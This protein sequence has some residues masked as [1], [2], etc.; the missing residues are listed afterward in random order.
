VRFRPEPRVDGRRRAPVKGGGHHHDQYRP[1]Q[2]STER[3][4]FSQAFWLEVLALHGFGIT[5]QVSLDEDNMTMS[6]QQLN[7]DD[8]VEER[9]KILEDW[10]GQLESI[11]DDVGDLIF[12]IKSAEPLTLPRGIGHALET[13]D[14]CLNRVRCWL[15]DRLHGIPPHR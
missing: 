15:E 6:E 8:V 10:L 4:D 14:C 5:F 13:I 12:A 7:I 9:H 3:N 11:D 1:T 2:G